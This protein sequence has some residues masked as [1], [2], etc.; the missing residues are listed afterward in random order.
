MGAIKQFVPASKREQ[1]KKFAEKRKKLVAPKAV[2]MFTITAGAA[3]DRGNKGAYFG[4][5]RN[6]QSIRS[7]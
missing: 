6:K 2:H 7:L 3:K 4:L 1:A 5:R